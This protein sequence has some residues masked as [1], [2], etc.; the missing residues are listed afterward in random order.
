MHKGVVGAEN[1]QGS[2]RFVPDA[3]KTV[4]V[5]EEV[6]GAVVQSFL[7]GYPLPVGHEAAHAHLAAADALLPAYR[8]GRL[9]DD[10]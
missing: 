8:V 10:T 3:L 5:Q 9:A 7:A 6:D 4:V 1:R 2:G